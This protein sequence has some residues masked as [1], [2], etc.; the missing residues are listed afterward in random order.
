MQL[1][2]HR[3]AD[4]SSSHPGLLRTAKIKTSV[5]ELKKL[6][7]PKTEKAVLEALDVLLKSQPKESFS[8]TSNNLKESDTKAGKRFEVVIIEEGLGNF[9]DAFYYPGETL[10]QCAAI[11]EG[12]KI[13]ADHPSSLDEQTRPERS[14]RDILGYFENC[15]VEEDGGR[16]ILKAHAIIPD[17]AAFDWARALMKEALSY[18]ERHKD[19]ELVGLSIN[20]SGDA[21]EMPI[22]DAIASAPQPAK[23]KLEEAR[24][25]G[26]ESVK[27]VF[28]ITDATSADLVTEAGAGGKII[29]LMEGD[30]SMS[31]KMKEA[32]PAHPDAAQDKALIMD[33]IK[34][35]M[36]AKGADGGAPAPGGDDGAGEK[37]AAE[38]PEESMDESGMYEM[39]QA[40]CGEGYEAEE[41]A[42]MCA[43][44]HKVG[45][46]KEAAAKK[47][48][49]EKAPMEQPAE[50]A[51]KEDGE[52]MPAEE[53]KKESS[54]IELAGRVSFLEGE[55]R[56]ERLAKHIEKTLAESKLPRVATDSIRALTKDVKTEKQFNE[57]FALFCEGY[58]AKP[59]E[60]MS[61]GF[62]FMP[63]KTGMN[64]AFEV[65]DLSEC[66]K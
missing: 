15:R 28:E 64:E 37:P 47:E 49:D 22:A 63:E 54:A 14:T 56:K 35:H 7:D 2:G 51:K 58:K 26:I 60:D 17:G 65:L 21:K 39:H 43:A 40:L 30:K 50:A 48:A 36:G 9:G 19:K 13:Y 24:A 11:F 53:K 31:K 55:L 1:R 29:K 61:M 59:V 25:K 38:K 32:D 44:F 4:V 46:K 10:Q 52:E 5:E 18:K 42:K 8:F 33:M 45:K 20:A 34:K 3:E 66:V 57:S 62:A 16:K 12:K 27:Y 41:A 6:L 23:A